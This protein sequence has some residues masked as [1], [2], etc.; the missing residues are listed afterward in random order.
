MFGCDDKYMDHFLGS[1]E[2][3]NRSLKVSLKLKQ[4]TTNKQYKGIKNFCDFLN[5]NTPKILDG[6]TFNTITMLNSTGNGKMN[7]SVERDDRGSS[8]LWESASIL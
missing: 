6:M 8:K 4:W 3:A 5:V 7:P 1:L 2:L